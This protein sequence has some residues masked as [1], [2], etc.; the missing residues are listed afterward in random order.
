MA[1]RPKKSVKRKR[2]LGSWLAW[3][4]AAAL[5]AVVV[6]GG[7][8]AF[9]G[10]DDPPERSVRR[11]TPVVVDGLE[12]SVEVVDTD[13]EPRAL[14][15]PVGATV[16][17][18]FEGDAAHDVTEDRGLFASDTMTSG[19]FSY[20]FDEPGEY[21]YY[22]TL[23]HRMQGTITVGDGASPTATAAVTSSAP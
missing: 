2:R 17:W 12:A 15:V 20:T 5:V 7:F 1:K 11:P 4:G 8:L 21:F 23:H 3:G 13:Y 18:S 14:K 10:G 9:G 19:S 6:A 22:C 16:T